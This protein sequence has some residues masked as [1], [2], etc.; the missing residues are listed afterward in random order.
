MKL[1]KILDTWLLD[2]KEYI[3]QTN[4]IIEISFSKKK[5]KKKKI[6]IIEIGNDVKFLNFAIIYLSSIDTTGRSHNCVNHMSIVYK[7]DHFG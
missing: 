6:Y 4:Y 5:K 7:L 3:I 1:F 2:D